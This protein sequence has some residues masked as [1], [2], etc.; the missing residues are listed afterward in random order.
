[1]SMPRAL[2][3]A[4]TLVLGGCEDW[5]IPTLKE[6]ATLVDY[7]RDRPAS[8]FPNMPWNDY[9]WAIGTATSQCESGFNVYVNF[10]FGYID[11]GTGTCN[12]RCVSGE[13]MKDVFG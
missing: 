7:G 6:L 10:K 2:V 1:M 4:D 5:R 12:V 8:T 3:Y 9:V 11:T 13:M